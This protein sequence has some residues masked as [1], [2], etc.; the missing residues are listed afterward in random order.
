[1]DG[2]DASLRRTVTETVAAVEQ[3]YWILVAA[4][5]DVAIRE[6][7]MQLAERQRS[8]AQVRV[9]AQVLPE[10]DLAQFTAE[11]ERRRGDL[12]G[13]RETAARAELSLKSLILESA[14]SPLWSQTLQLDDPPPP[15]VTSTVDLQAALA[16][17]AARPELADSDA[18]LALQQIRARRGARSPAPAADL[19]GGYTA[20]GV[21]GARSPDVRPFPGLTVEFQ[22]ELQGALGASLE[23]V[24]L[25]RFP[26]VT[27]GV[28]LT[29]PL[30]YRAAHADIAT[31]ESQRRQIEAAR[32]RIRIA[33][34]R[35]GAQ[36]RHRAP[37]R[38]A[39]IEAARAT[40]D[41]A[42]IELRAEEDR[43]SAGATT[44]FFV[45]TR[46]T[47][48]PPP[49][50]PTPRPP[51]PTAAPSPSWH[52]PAARC[53]ATAPSTGGRHHDAIPR[54]AL[55]CLALAGAAA[56]RQAAD[57]NLIRLNGRIEAVMVDI[58]PK[59]TGRVREVLVREGERVKAGDVLIRLDLGET[60]LSVARDRSQVAAAEARVRDLE[61]GSRTSEI[62]AAEADV[63]D[64]KAALAIPRRS[65]AAAVHARAQ[66]RNRAPYVERATTEVERLKAN[67]SGSESRLKLLREGA[68]LESGAAGAGRRGARENRAS[69]SRRRWSTKA[70]PRPADA[71]VVHRFAEPGQPSRPGSPG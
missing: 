60:T 24:A 65:V 4:R 37:D 6:S 8:D 51:R 7:T 68:R 52:A 22:D 56:C 19:V 54:S 61:A 63:R 70:S 26:D 49:R 15:A 5:R 44:P 50:S 11:I 1:M 13:S 30:G 31:A 27:A 2:S 58:S 35:R 40:L 18:R 12:Y 59:V 41:A 67:V 17:A 36:R 42:R 10:S 39:A 62:A 29:I 48:P 53:C 43:L 55:V 14:D 47:I 9:E 3:A 45:L 20:R 66:G 46:Q 33:Y 21:A 34:R 57:P 32:E 38:G 69:S 64:R 23:S 71:I 16:D 28:Q 25:Q